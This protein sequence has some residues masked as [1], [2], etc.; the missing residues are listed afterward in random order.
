MNRKKYTRVGV[1]DHCHWTS[2]Y[3]GK[4]H[5]FCNIFYHGDNKV[6]VFL[7][8]GTYV[9]FFFLKSYYSLTTERIFSIGSKYDTH[10]FLKHLSKHPDVFKK[11]SVIGEYF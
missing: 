7:H 4:A 3:R 5:A 8:N 6:P 2:E 10:F 1:M 11:P 9:H